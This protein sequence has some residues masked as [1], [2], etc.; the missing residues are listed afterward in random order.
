[1]VQGANQGWRVVSNFVPS[2]SKQLEMWQEDDWDDAII[3]KELKG[4]SNL[5]H[6]SMRVFLHDL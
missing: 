2:T 4:A 3:E 1:M 6:N 5:G